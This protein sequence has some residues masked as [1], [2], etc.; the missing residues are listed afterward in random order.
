MP[1]NESTE[2]AKYEDLENVVVGDDPDKF[3]QVDSQLPPQ[4]KEEL[5]EFLRK[6]IDVFAWNAYKAPRVDLNFICHHLNVNPAVT[7]KKQSHRHS[8]RDHSVAIKDEVT[9]LK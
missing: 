9:K 2:E 7:P 1:D 6:N 8:S 4:E 5:I 3:F